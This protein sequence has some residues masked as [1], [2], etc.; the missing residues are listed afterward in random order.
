[1]IVEKRIF[2]NILRELS[3]VIVNVITK[4]LVGEWI[5]HED[6]KVKNLVL[7]EM[8]KVIIN[9]TFTTPR[10]I[11]K[12]LSE[13]SINVIIRKLARELKGNPIR[14]YRKFSILCKNLQEFVRGN[15]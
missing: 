2:S 4:Y 15:H 11:L 5:F 8:L 12:K 7:S 10:E 9:M 1:M 3:E 14:D 6:F 13:V